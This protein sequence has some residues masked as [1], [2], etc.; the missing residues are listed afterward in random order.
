ML[1]IPIILTKIYF[2]TNFCIFYFIISASSIFAR[3]GKNLEFSVTMPIDWKLNN[4]LNEVW[5]S[6]FWIILF[7]RQRKNRIFMA[8]KGFKFLSK[9]QNSDFWQKCD[10]FFRFFYR[11]SAKSRRTA[12]RPTA[13]SSLLN[14]LTILIIFIKIYFL[15][16]FFIFCKGLHHLFLRILAKIKNFQVRMPIDWKLSNEL[17][18]VWHSSFWLILLLWQLKNWI[19]IAKNA[20]S[21]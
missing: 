20:K 1:T 18:E 3:S 17:N 11:S 16:N 6:S 8:K 21:Y 19:F 15:T 2:L 14:M 4:D 5:H 12:I 10:I 13:L 9:I 7:L